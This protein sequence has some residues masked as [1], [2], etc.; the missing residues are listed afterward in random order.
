MEI[1]LVNMVYLIPVNTNT[2]K[3]AGLLVKY[4]PSELASDCNCSTF[5]L[6]VVTPLV[7]DI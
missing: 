3:Q 1:S 7:G 2:S 4:L 6:H 5:K